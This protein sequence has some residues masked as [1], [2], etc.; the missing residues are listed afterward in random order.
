MLP[1][2]YSLKW[3]SKTSMAKPSEYLHKE[4]AVMKDSNSANNNRTEKNEPEPLSAEEPLAVINRQ[5]RQFLHDFHQPLTVIMATS[6]LMQ[7]RELDEVT[8][9]DVDIIFNAAND[10]E[11]LAARMREFIQKM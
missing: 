1:K 6:Q 4:P 8:T 3:N 5:L 2:Q 11:K 9:S 7:L 10:L